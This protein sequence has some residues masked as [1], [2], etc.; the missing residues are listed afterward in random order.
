MWKITAGFYFIWRK[1]MY[2]KKILDNEA[3]VQVLK[4]KNMTI[5]NENEVF[6]FRANKLQ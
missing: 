2:N 3:L 6:I 4:N 1:I 5:K